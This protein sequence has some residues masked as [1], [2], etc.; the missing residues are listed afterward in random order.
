MRGMKR[1]HL[2]RNQWLLIALL[3]TITL[4]HVAMWTSD[5]MTTDVKLR[6][7]LINALGWAIV[8]LPAFAVGKWLEAK[9]RQNARNRR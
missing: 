4:A 8:L 7:T 9:Q 6:L 3:C 1:P 5:R 2:S